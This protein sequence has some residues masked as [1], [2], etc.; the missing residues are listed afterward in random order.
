MEPS[1]QARNKTN[2]GL[3]Y[4][5]PIQYLYKN[6]K[7]RWIYWQIEIDNWFQQTFQQIGRNSNRQRQIDI[8]EYFLKMLIQHTYATNLRIESVILL[9]TILINE[10][11][12]GPAASNIK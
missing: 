3:V 9:R 4:R 12:P 2:T 8:K 10:Y 11:F 6:H 1:Q 5:S 7:L